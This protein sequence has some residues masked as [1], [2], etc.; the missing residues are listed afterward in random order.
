MTNKLCYDKL[1]AMRKDKR[2]GFHQLLVDSVAGFMET[3][4]W[5]RDAT[6]IAPY[7]VPDLKLRKPGVAYL[8]FM[9]VKPP[10]VGVGEINKGIGEC[11]SYLWRKDVKPYLVIHQN[12]FV[13][14]SKLLN[15]PELYWLG[16]YAYDNHILRLVKSSGR[17]ITEVLGQDYTKTLYISNG[18]VNAGFKVALGVPQFVGVEHATV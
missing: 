8:A 17:E 11:A 14:F 18:K 6:I 5:Y 10:Y 2:Q 1:K 12:H 3:E 9:E 16:V 13:S 15:Q 4:G 7:S